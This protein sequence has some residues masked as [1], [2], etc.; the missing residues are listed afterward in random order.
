MISE[1]RVREWILASLKTVKDAE[2]IYKDLNLSDETVIL[3]AG[4]P[5]DSIAFT[6]FATDLEEKIEDET[7]REYLLKVDEIFQPQ[8]GHASLTVKDLAKRIPRLIGQESRR[9]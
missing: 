4:S 7:G 5:F 6:A 8:K 1:S 3:G 9:V 2:E